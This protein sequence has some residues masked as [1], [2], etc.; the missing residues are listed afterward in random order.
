MNHCSIC[1][2]NIKFYHRK[3][4]YY[5]CNHL[6]HS[7]CF[8]KFMESSYGMHNYCP[9]CRSIIKVK[10]FTDYKWDIDIK[11][12][13]SKLGGYKINNL[14]KFINLILKDAFVN[15][16]FLK[17]FETCIK[18]SHKFT[19]CL[20]SAQKAHPFINDVQVKCYYCG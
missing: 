14:D 6:L 15:S 20:S 7:T 13:E 11:Y 12:L 2:G 16:Q 5:H 19:F 4:R 18:R 10:Y 17:T 8:D 9:Q 1:L 3:A